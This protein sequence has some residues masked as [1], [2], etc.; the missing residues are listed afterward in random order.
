MP[1]LKPI[2]SVR[3]VDPKA[4]FGV[5][6]RPQFT[7]TY[8]FADLGAVNV[9]NR[10]GFRFDLLTE[11]VYNEPVFVPHENDVEGGYY[12][13]GSEPV[14]IFGPP[15]GEVRLGTGVSLSA[16]Q[17]P[18]F[19]TKWLELTTDWGVQNANSYA[20]GWAEVLPGTWCQGCK[21]FFTRRA[22]SGGAANV[23]SSLAVRFWVSNN[24]FV[25][26][27]F[28]TG[29]SIGI[30]RL[31]RR[32]DAETFDVE[33]LGI[34]ASTDDT[35][36][37]ISEQEEGTSVEALYLNQRMAIMLHGN[38]TPMLIPI[39]E[40]DGEGESTRW[41]RY[42]GFKAAC[43]DQVR[44]SF[45]PTKF[46]KDAFLI[47]NEENLGF[48]LDVAPEFRVEAVYTADEIPGH[49]VDCY[50]PE[51]GYAM[52]F[53]QFE[54]DVSHTEHGVY[55]GQAWTHKTQAIKAVT[56]N[57]PGEAIKP[58]SPWEDLSW[59]VNPVTG[60]RQSYVRE[61]TISHAFDFN[62]LT[63][64]SQAEVSFS[65]RHGEW[66]DVGGLTALQIFLGWEHLGLPPTPQ[67]TGWG[68]IKHLYNRPGAPESIYTMLCQDASY[69][70]RS[71]E[72]HNVPW[73]DGWCHYYAL[74]FI[75][76]LG[77]LHVDQLRYVYDPAVGYCTAPNC[78][79]DHYFLPMGDGGR[80]LMSFPPGTPFWDIM[81]RI[82]RLTGYLLYFDAQ[83]YLRYEPWVR[84]APGPYKRQFF[85]RP[86][87]TNDMQA[88]EYLSVVRDT[89]AVRNHLTIVG[90]DAYAP[91]WRPV[92]AHR[93]DWSSLEQYGRRNYMGFRRRA[94]WADSQFARLDYAAEAADMIFPVV[95]MPQ[96][97][98]TFLCRG[99]P[100]LYPLDVIQIFE[101]PP[102]KT[103]VTQYQGGG[104]RFFFITRITHRM[105]AQ[106]TKMDFTS[107][108][109]G[110]WI[111]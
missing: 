6:T 28:E 52:Q 59:R 48:N 93:A 26:V 68:G 37:Q 74:R 88:L 47:T 49:T 11:L 62:N 10:G 64:W 51:G 108:I 71:D 84:T 61:I 94:I 27:S 104:P 72:A 67:F 33:V 43:F 107:T 40:V 38:T 53:V 22:S 23:N 44:L 15:T 19:D 8:E 75:A 109:T 17:R 103:G 20:E 2:Q 87:P 9:A 55:K 79:H 110:R 16:A 83:G 3:C 58:V 98:V 56:M 12:A 90:I 35:W 4:F 32:G 73:L 25:S 102:G 80:P 82:R 66:K 5:Q 111:V 86:G 7:K 78:G 97:E 36:S 1:V 106:G 99:Q 39:P 50:V 69:Q 42:V 13:Q 14:L 29:K 54:M 46:A 105:V 91:M 92:V 76:Q 18:P 63:V 96:E 101:L 60:L 89:D 21:V 70:L 34:I 31:W 24:L 45:N 77:G 85:E 95:S 100:D 81:L 57:I 65:N 30:A 41:I